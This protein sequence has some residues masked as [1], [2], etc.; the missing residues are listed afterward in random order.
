MACCVLATVP[1]TA[2]QNAVSCC[3]VS[4][5]TAWNWQAHY[6]HHSC[7]IMCEKK[8]A[9]DMTGRRS[10]LTTREEPVAPGIRKAMLK[11]EPENERVMSQLGRERGKVKMEWSIPASTFYYYLNSYAVFFLSYSCAVWPEVMFYKAVP[12]QC[13]S[14]IIP[15]SALCRTIRSFFIVLIVKYIFAY[16]FKFPYKINQQKINK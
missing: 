8:C 1:G 6:E 7:A 13:A 9:R 10:C 12:C 4:P 3:S 14:V 11:E 16:N 5:P 15:L 2:E